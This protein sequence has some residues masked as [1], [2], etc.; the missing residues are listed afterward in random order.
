MPP[1]A[2]HDWFEHEVR[3]H[4]SLLR[5]WLTS[6]YPA[7]QDLDDIVQEAY[8]RVIQARSRAEIAAPKAY[9]FKVARNLVLDRLRHEHALAFQSLADSPES[10]VL[11]PAEPVPQAVHHD[12]QLELMTEAIQSLPKQ[13]RR[14]FTLRKVYG[15]SQAEIAQRMGL[16]VNTVSAQLTIGLQKCRLYIAGRLTPLD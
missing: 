15:L 11:D 12:Q 5:A 3:A 4:E 7:V 13:C 9:L 8:V 2:D 14:I 6:R 16:S 1:P 10:D